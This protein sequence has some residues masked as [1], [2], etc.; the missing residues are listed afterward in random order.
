METPEE[1]V[2]KLNE[3]LESDLFDLNEF[4]SLIKRFMLKVKTD[5]KFLDFEYYNEARMESARSNKM[6][7]VTLKDFEAAAEFRE[8][9]RECQKYIE[10][11]TEYN[12]EKSAFYYGNDQLFYFCLG[13]AKNEKFVRDYLTD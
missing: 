7:K 6:A 2:Q 4:D 12:L 11:K 1:I 5:I 3:L 13:T 10:I 9:E 8:M